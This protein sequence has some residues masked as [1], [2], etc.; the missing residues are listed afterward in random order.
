[1]NCNEAAEFISALCDGER[2]PSDA[3]AHVGDCPSCQARMRDYLA[4]G[5]E[6][7]RVASL[8]FAEE[9]KPMAWETKQSGISTLWQKGWETMRIPRFAFAALVVGIVALG[10]SLAMVKVRAHSDGTVLMLA[11]SRGSAE[12]LPCPLATADKN[13]AQCAAFGVMGK[14]NVGYQIS[15]LG[16]DGNRV[17]LGMR[18]KVY[19]P[20][21]G[22]SRAFELDDFKA[23]QQKQYWFEPGQTLRVDLAGGGVLSVTGEWTDHIPT[24]GSLMGRNHDLDPGPDEMRIVSP[25]LLRDKKVVGDLEGGSTLA[26]EPDQGVLIY[27]PSEG[28]FILSL[29]KQEGAVEG[30]AN[31]NR[32]SFKS[33]ERNYTF[34]TGEPVARSKQVWILHGRNLDPANEATKFGFITSGAVNELRAIATGKH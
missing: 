27:L 17:Q 19:S 31:M 5:A 6:M 1:M 16:R 4:M 26:N 14:S 13:N 11:V 21:A 20:L 33:G 10:S 34:L 9:A 23:E 8:E 3:A 32:I 24:A 12:A 2:I 15:F 30:E 28:F 22:A 18:T 7:R 29:Q 25:L